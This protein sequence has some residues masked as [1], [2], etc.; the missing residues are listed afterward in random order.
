M[1]LRLMC[2]AIVGVAT[3]TAFSL[4]AQES[5]SQWNG[6]Y[7]GEQAKRGE[8]AYLKKCAACHVADLTGGADEYNPA[9]A[10]IGA[11]FVEN[12][13]DKTL[14]ELFTKIHTTM[15]Q[16]DPG[17]LTLQETSDIIAFMLQKANYPLGTAELP[18]QD[19][20]LKAYKFLAKKPEA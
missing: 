4:S 11:Q 7:T 2:L 9:P 19:E 16:D 8:A 15:P 20:S 10:L 3:T 1:R 12:W 13:N 5:K 18:A 6:V 17:K 14:A